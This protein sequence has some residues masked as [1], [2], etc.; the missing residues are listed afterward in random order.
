MQAVALDKKPQALVFQSCRP[1][2]EA[3][4]SGFQELQQLKFKPVPDYET[5]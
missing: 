2:Q 4:D 3:R 5:I 1:W